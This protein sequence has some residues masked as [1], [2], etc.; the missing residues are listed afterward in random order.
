MGSP[1]APMAM[2]MAACSNTALTRLP[3]ALL[4]RLPSE[5]SGG[6]RQRVALMR[7]LMLDPDVLL[8]D[9]PLAALDPITRSDLQAELRDIFRA[10][11][12]T[13]VLVTHDIGEAAFLASTIVMLRDGHILQSGSI[14]ALVQRPSDPFITRFIAA[15]RPPLGVAS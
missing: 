13:V 12:K 14:E 9:E 4:T 11:G 5:L 8:L 1:G 7:A 6:Q 10:L 15:Q 2:P 3:E